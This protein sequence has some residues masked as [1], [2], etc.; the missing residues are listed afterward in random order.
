MSTTDTSD[1]SETSEESE[2][3]MD[4]D[5][6]PLPEGPPPPSAVKATENEVENKKKE[7]GDEDE[8]D[9]DDDIPLPSGPPPPQPFQRQ[10]G[11]I[12]AA[13][14]MRPPPPPPP[15]PG[16]PTVHAPPVN[17]YAGAPM[18]VP[19]PPP[20]R[21]S[22]PFWCHSCRKL[23]LLIMNS[24]NRTSSHAAPADFAT[25][26]T[27]TT[28]SS[29]A[30][31]TCTALSISGHCCWKSCIPTTSSQTGWTRHY[32]RRAEAA[33]LAKGIAQFCTSFYTAKAAWSDQKA[34]K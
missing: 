29:G 25:P 30:S 14:G 15:P 32:F 27:A 10:L 33:R 7:A 20:P 3:E 5:D 31:A 24:R 17:Y 12:Q 2:S 26:A 8:D 6:I 34:S 19:P 22:F 23:D 1:E 21:K 4:D 11:A 28:V 18:M 16:R 13:H 9:D